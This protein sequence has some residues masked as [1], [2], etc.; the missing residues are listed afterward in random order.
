MSAFPDTCTCRWED[1]GDGHPECAIGDDACDCDAHHCRCD[2]VQ[3]PG[4]GQTVCVP[5]C[6]CE[7][8][9]CGT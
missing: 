9:G 5:E 3:E 6:D 1:D 7:A 4:T 8:C 2:V